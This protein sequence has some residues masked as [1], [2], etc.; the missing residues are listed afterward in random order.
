MG[1]YIIEKNRKMDSYKSVSQFSIEPYFYL[2][3]SQQNWMT[4]LCHALFKYENKIRISWD[5]WLKTS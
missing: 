2:F 1:I 5:N 4:E 3:S